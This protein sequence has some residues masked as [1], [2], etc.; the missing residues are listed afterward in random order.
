MIAKNS[1]Y[2]RIATE[3]GWMTPELMKMYL[4]ILDHKTIDDPGFYSLWGFFATHHSPRAQDLFARI[5]DLGERRLSD[6]DAAGID[7][8]L[9]MLTAPGVQV[10]DKETAV[11]LARSTND[12]LAQTIKDHPTRFTGLAAIAPQDPELAAKEIERC[13]NHLGLKG[14]L[15]NSHT[16]GEYLDDEKFWPIF[17][18]AQALDVPIYL[19]PNSPSPQ[20]VEPYLSRCLDAAILGFAA[21]TSLHVLRLIVSGLFDRFP[22]LKMVLGHLGEGLPYWHHRIDFM[23]GGIVRAKR[24]PGVQA[25]KRLPSDYLRENFGYT[26]S[27]MPWEPAISF[28]QKI[29]GMDRV[30]YAMDYPYQYV[31]DEVLEMDNLPLSVEH[32]KMFYQTNA[33]HLFK[34]N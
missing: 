6:M 15:I 22:K 14:A 30:M 10:F 9:L 24:S 12:H 2:K 3:E 25:L 16:Q 21:E 17:E 20:M 19:H 18:A 7:V 5:Q 34:L 28:A 26:T 29:M 11:D 33:E 27:G 32:K 8:Q 4:H 31:P 13:V 1:H 23:H